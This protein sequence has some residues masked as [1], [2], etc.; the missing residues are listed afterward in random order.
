MVATTTTLHQILLM[1]TILP[2]LV[3]I[4]TRIAAILMAGATRGVTQVVENKVK[5]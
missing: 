4:P 1:D 5:L 3:V 2:G